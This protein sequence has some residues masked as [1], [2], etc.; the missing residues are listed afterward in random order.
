VPLADPLVRFAAPAEAEGDAEADADAWR[1]ADGPADAD[2][3]ALGDAEAEAPARPSSGVRDTSNESA[4]AACRSSCPPQADVTAST[5]RAA[6][7]IRT[8]RGNVRTLSSLQR[9]RDG[10]P[11]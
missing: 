6:V 10:G 11:R 1:E 9:G 5:P 2:A 4:A 3:E 7:V 8:W